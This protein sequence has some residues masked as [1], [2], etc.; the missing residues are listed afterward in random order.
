MT[1]VIIWGLWF[2]IGWTLMELLFGRGGLLADFSW[3]SRKQARDFDEFLIRTISSMPMAPGP[4]VTKATLASGSVTK[5]TLA[6][7]S[8]TRTPKD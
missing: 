1:D 8:V 3:Q 2:Y 5:A 4:H 7:N 6:P